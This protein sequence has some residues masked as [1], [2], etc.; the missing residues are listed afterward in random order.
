MYV[1][2]GEVEERETEMMVIRF[3]VFQ[4]SYQIP[5]S[6]QKTIDP[7]PT[8]FANVIFENAIASNWKY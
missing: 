7:C 4:L 5:L 8:C 6:D 3:K 2:G 1:R